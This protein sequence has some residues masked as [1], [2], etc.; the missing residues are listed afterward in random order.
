M[1]YP[2]P[3]LAQAA[4]N[5]TLRGDATASPRMSLDDTIQRITMLRNTLYDLQNMA[6]AKYENYHGV[7]FSPPTNENEAVR[8]A[9]VGQVPILNSVIADMEQTVYKIGAMLDSFR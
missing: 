2:T 9:I 3:E 6:S 7:M 1:G 4:M 8:Q 5:T